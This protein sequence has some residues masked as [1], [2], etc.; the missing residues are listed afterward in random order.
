MAAQRV[1]W[2]V[3]V[4]QKRDFVNPQELMT[5]CTWIFPLWLCP[6]GW[7]QIRGL[8]SGEMLL[9]ELLAQLLRP[10][11]GQAV[12]CPVPWVKAD[13]I[14]VAFHIFPF[15]VFLIAEIGSHTGNSEILAPA[16][17]GRNAVILPR[18]QP[19]VFIKGGLSW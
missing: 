13:D 3:H 15:L 10:V 11:Y 14:V 2:S 6:S 18:Y 12:V 9:A 17:E 1:G 19:P 5:I 7:V 16:V 8:V 4:G